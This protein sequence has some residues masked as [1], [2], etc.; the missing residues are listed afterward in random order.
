MMPSI[1]VVDDSPDIHALLEVRLRSEGAVLRHALTPEAGLESARTQPPDVILLDVEMPG[2]SGF[3]VCKELKADPLTASIPVIFLSGQLDQ[4]AKVM[5]LDLGAVDYVTKPFDIA[6]LRARVRV[7]LRLKSLQDQLVTL[8]RIDQL[9]GLWNRAY[10]D[11]R[12]QQELAASDRSG[13]PL[14]LVMFDVDHFKR[15]NDGHG[16]PA[17]DAVLRTIA[18]R[19]LGRCAPA[20][21][22]AATAAKSLRSSCRAHRRAARR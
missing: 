21:S 14:S 9:T 3:D 12:L 15:V 20:T 7:S 5:G 2:R 16:H 6:E 22:F 10:F 8:A 4:R 17:G 13:R 11:G 19:V 1:L 18:A